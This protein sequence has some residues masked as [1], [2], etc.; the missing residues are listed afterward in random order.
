MLNLMKEPPISVRFE[1]EDLDAVR[2]AA[3]L[4]GLDPAS[5]CRRC[6]V[7]YTREKH[8]EVYQPG[9]PANSE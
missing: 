4:E 5:Y 3:K 9:D 7:R 1:K 2:E 8:P 6:T